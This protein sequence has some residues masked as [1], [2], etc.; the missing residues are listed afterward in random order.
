MHYHLHLIPRTVGGS[1]IPVCAWELKEGDMEAIK[2][3]AD[4]IAAAIK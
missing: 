2:Q 3:T 1:E 4:K